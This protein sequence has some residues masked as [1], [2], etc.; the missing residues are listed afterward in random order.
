MRHGYTTMEEIRNNM[1]HQLDADTVM[2]V[3]S[4]NGAF[5]VSVAKELIHLAEELSNDAYC[6]ETIL[7]MFDYARRWDNAYIEPALN[8]LID[9]WLIP[10]R[11]EQE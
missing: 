7:W 9:A 10:Y 11:R 3:C 8:E 1:A 2:D 5:G 4:Y 6:K